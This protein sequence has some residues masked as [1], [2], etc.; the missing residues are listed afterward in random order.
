MRWI[1]GLL[2]AGLV[3]LAPGGSAAAKSNLENIA[4]H[5]LKSSSELEKLALPKIDQPE[6]LKK[7]IE[8]EAVAV[9]VPQR[10]GSG[11]VTV[12]YSVTTA[13]AITANIQEFK[14]QANQTLNSGSG[15]ARMGVHFNE[16]ASGGNFTLVL[17]EASQLPVYSSDCSAEYSCRAGRFVIINQDRWLY[18]TPSWNSGGGGLRDYRHMVINHEVG[19]WLGHGHA[20]CGGAGQAAPVMQQQSIDLQGCAFNAWPLVTELWSTQLG[21]R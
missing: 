10:S 14:T 1:F 5:D 21:I 16:V 2:I 7:A 11:P 15:W 4:V 17:A 20:Y 8:A 18:A 3:A 6:W 19:H 13:G 9:G 12:T